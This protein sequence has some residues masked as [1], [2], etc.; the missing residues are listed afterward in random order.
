MQFGYYDHD[1]V[2]HSMPD[3]KDA[4]ATVEAIRKK[5]DDEMQLS[6][7]EFNRKYEDFLEAQ[8][9]F[10]TPILRKRMAELQDIYER[11][12]AFRDEAKRLLAEMEKSIYAPVEKRLQDAIAEIALKRGLAFVMKGSNN[13][14]PY[15]DKSVGY[16]LTG[17]LIMLLNKQ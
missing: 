10:T 14:L 16:D 1:S 15:V 6:A 5:Y 3:Y 12:M 9:T 13:L 4:A 11:N 7:S 8:S 2:L 17:E